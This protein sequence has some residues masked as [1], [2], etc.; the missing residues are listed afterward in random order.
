MPTPIICF[1]FDGTLVDGQG[2]IHPRDIEILAGERSAI[3]IPT[4]GRPLHSVRY[5]FEQNGLFV[6]QPIPFHLVLQ[7][8]AAVYRPDEILHAHH[9]FAPDVQAALIETA[10][11]YPQVTFFLF[12]L[13]EVYVLWPNEVGMAMARRFALD[14]Q[15]FVQS[16]RQRRFTKL[17]G[18]AKAPDP[19]R[20][21]ATAIADLA[22]E[23]FYSLPTVLEINRAGIDKGRTLAALLDDLGLDSTHVIAAGDGEN[24]LPLFDLATLSFSPDTSPAAIR[25][26]ADHVVNVRETGLLAPLLQTIGLQQSQRCE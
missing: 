26:R 15:P 21:V 25:A 9:P 13:A 19:L 1:D 22:L 16:S 6:G 24:D 14:T 11:S 20:A 4:T 18:I 8:G 2:R 7:N 23:R 10:L 5:T 3:F 17:M 12:S